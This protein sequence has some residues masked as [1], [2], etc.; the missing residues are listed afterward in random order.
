MRLLRTQATLLLTA[1][2]ICGSPVCGQVEVDAIADNDGIGLV[3]GWNSETDNYR[4][5]AMNDASPNPA[6]DG[7]GGP[8]LK[9]KKANGNACL[10]S[11]GASNNCFDTLS[12]LTNGGA[13]ALRT[14]SHTP[15]D[16]GPTNF[17]HQS[18]NYSWPYQLP[19]PF[20][21]E[22]PYARGSYFSNQYTMTLI[23][24]NGEATMMFYKDGLPVA[25]RAP[26]PSTYAGGQIGLF[27]Y[28]HTATFTNVRVTDLTSSNQP[29]GYCSG[30]GTCDST[31]GVCLT[32]P[33]TP[34]PPSP[35]PIPP[36]VLPSCET[37]DY[38]VSYGGYV[39]RTLEPALITGTQYSTSVEKE[40]LP[41][42]AGYQIAPN[43]DASN[44]VGPNVI[45]MYPWN[46]YRICTDSECYGGAYYST[47]GTV[48][49]TSRR[50]ESNGTH[51]R[52]LPSASSWYRVL[53]RIECDSGVA[54]TVVY[55]SGTS[56]ITGS[57]GSPSASGSIAVTP[58]TLY[59][60]TMEALRNDLGSASERVTAVR[61]N[62]ADIGGCNPDGG[63]YDCTFFDCEVQMGA[64]YF[65][66]SAATVSLEVDITGHSWDCDCDTTTWECSRENTVAGRTPMNAVAR[67]TFEP[68]AAGTTIVV[69]YNSGTTATT[70]APG[71]P[72][73]TTTATVVPGQTY[74]ITTTVLRNDL[75]SSS[76]RVTAIRIGGTNIGSCNPNGGDYDCTFFDCSS[77]LGGET[78]MT[79]TTSTMTFEVDITGHSWDC[80]CDT[81]TWE[82]SRENTV[83]GRTPMNAVARFLLTP[84]ST[85][86]PAM[87]APP[88]PPSPPPPP[89]PNP[90]PPDG[91][92][93][94][95]AR[96][97]W[98]RGLDD[99]SVG[100]Q[101]TP[102]QC[103]D[104]CYARYGS[105]LVAIDIDEF[106]TDSDSY[107]DATTG[108]R[109]HH[110]CCQDACPTCVGAGTETLITM[111]G[112]GNLPA[113]C[114]DPA[115]GA[116]GTLQCGPPP[117]PP[118]GCYTGNGA[119]YQGGVSVTNTGLT[120]QVW[121]SQTPH[122]HSRTPANYPEFHLGNHNYC[123]NPDGE[124]SPWC[125]TMDPNV[126]W[127]LCNQI[128]QCAPP[129]P[130][131]PLPPMLPPAPPEGCYSGTGASY[132][133]GMDTTV[134]G[135]TCQ[136]WT[137]QSPHGHSRT[138]ANYPNFGLGDHNYCRNPDGEPA[139]WCYTTDVNT[140]WQLCT[141]IPTCSVA[142]DP[143]VITTSL[144]SAMMLTVTVSSRTT[145]AATDWIGIY[146]QATAISWSDAYPGSGSLMWIYLPTTDPATVTIDLSTLAP[147]DYA[148]LQLAS[149]GYAR[150]TQSLF[151]IIAPP[152]PPTPPGPPTCYFPRAGWC[153]GID[154]CGVGSQPTPQACWDA[155]YA[156]Y[157]SS[158]V[159]IDI[160]EFE[161]DG[162]SYTDPTTGL[163]M[164]HCCCQDA[165][166]SCVGSGTE[167]LVVVGIGALP[168][169]CGDPTASPST[170]G[171]LT[172]APT[173]LCSETCNYSSDN[174]C[175]D[176]GDGAEFSSCTVGS[177][178]LDC[179]P[180]P[181]PST[182]SY[183]AF[184]VTGRP[185]SGEQDVT[186]GTMYLTSSDLELMHDGS[187]QQVVGIIFPAVLLTS[188]D[189]ATL[190]GTHLVFDVDEVRAQSAGDVTVRIF[191]ELSASPAAYS[192]TLFDITSRT[193][194]T[195]TVTWAIP[196]STTVHELLVSP[197]ISSIVSEIIGLSAWAPGASVA[198]MFEHVSGNG[199]RWIESARENTLAAARHGGFGMT[200]ALEVYNPS[201]PSPAGLCGENCNY[202]SDN[203]CD[204]GGAGAEF[205]ACS[206]GS[207]CQDCGSR[208]P[209]SPPPPAPAFTDP[210]AVPPPTFSVCEGAVGGDAITPSLTTGGVSDDV[211]TRIISHPDFDFI[212]DSPITSG[213]CSWY[214]MSDAA[215]MPGLHQGPTTAA[216][217][218]AS[219]V[220][221]ANAW[222]NSPGDNT[223]TGCNAMYKHREYTDFL[224][225]VDI[226]SFD[227]DGV[228][229][230]F[231]WRGTP[232]GTNGLA[233]SQRYVAA[234]INDIWPSPAADG[235][236]GPFMKIKRMNGSPC[237]GSMTS[238]DNCF[239]TLAYL[240]YAGHYVSGAGNALTNRT[241]HTLPSPYV[242]TYTAYP[243][244]IHLV[245]IVK[246]FEA[247]M[248]F[249]SQGQT[250][251]VKA[252][253]P[254]SY[255][256]GKIGF[257]TY[258]HT[259]WFQNLKIT[260]LSSTAS[261]M[262]VDYCNG[263][264]VC[265]TATGLCGDAPP[266][267]PPPPSAAPAPPGTTTA[268]AVSFTV[269]VLASEFQT[270]PGVYNDAAFVSYRASVAAL[271]T[272]SDT[273]ISLTVNGSP[274]TFGNRGRRLQGPTSTLDLQTTITQPSYAPSTFAA[275]VSATISSL[276]TNA[277]SES[278]GV[279][280]VAVVAAPT[281]AVVVQ[282]PTPP[283]PP[284]PPEMPSPM[285]AVTNTA[286]ALNAGDDDESDTGIIVAAVIG[287]VVVMILLAVLVCLT[288]QRKPKPPS[289]VLAAQVPVQM[290]DPG[291]VSKTSTTADEG[292]ELGESKDKI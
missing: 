180:R 75:G 122:S 234:M 287:G 197:D 101:N 274:Y 154:D 87:P 34:P 236:G 169:S 228:G 151:T 201:P 204:D 202:S 248:Y 156:R 268:Q 292:V 167:S 284:S 216:V 117:A 23:V 224:L 100:Y 168:A 182:P 170:L 135:K 181:A 278:L 81:T 11:M 271:A 89:P 125:Y 113:N 121:T 7:V 92:P 261:S 250:I 85:P 218:G 12:Y 160:D 65:T 200:P 290:M 166:P 198:I 27:T 17:N 43:S 38:Q 52:I 148:A 270:A 146:S 134:S 129:S 262:P 195:A 174:D 242:S 263:E 84:V 60:V 280:V 147:G 25:T 49:D 235:V 226:S 59:K 289:A 91:Q 210:S 185:D 80:D 109:M 139:P 131:P 4:A 260:D 56:A 161:T 141:H 105:S 115:T 86:P 126:R 193:R 206:L 48:R 247:R 244:N 231:G 20:Y 220:P 272:V 21:Q 36:V 190:T 33:S 288:Q 164:H 175:D 15:A 78:Y 277:L 40:W 79:A 133:G 50:W 67:F 237:T 232:V 2:P 266:S 44:S 10:G 283:P 208:A 225:E 189:A 69:A 143:G 158:L 254:S 249:Q 257:F 119:N 64:Y 209:T 194:T 212:D 251:G 273:M 138:P 123:R 104:V 245:L 291:A 8:F 103:W 179:G 163:R 265:E 203:D 108:L 227:N 53:L 97:G 221:G 217:S 3:F 199:I 205:T 107:T 211:E 120:C 41:I 137:A 233:A 258:A 241:A 127:Q 42:P 28:A 282:H 72:S 186:S 286:T 150:I 157:G 9:I 1:H 140:R 191:G 165:C 24:A 74:K 5:I 30:T 114:G 239:D 281:I 90:S 172:C 32:A 111:W 269:Q 145:S 54:S 124:P 238:T 39:Y 18:G 153:R 63:D 98:C 94:Y 14:L 118:D 155:C 264:A 246:N 77:Q 13:A 188:A 116:Q 214:V 149:D 46:A 222:G 207:D 187:S 66:P 223:L 102:Q 45:G 96:A 184:A 275:D 229:I 259:C 112:M 128:N 58:G 213:P 19:Y 279:T 31:L 47:A 183:Q 267:T 55:S 76:E 61:V 162:D 152:P 171:T 37:T 57:P 71:N 110:C 136:V 285:T 255:N 144:D 83:A 276:D 88:S 177:D 62:G 82:C 219:P 29:S 178:C 70:G 240:N 22:Y 176:G 93:C 68:V 256:G 6:A 51:A 230:N 142:S 192:S 253:L 196:P 159:A 106:E 16:W 95:F 99:C 130:P 35:P 132:R 243:R 26:L 215:N 252:P 73:A 173:G